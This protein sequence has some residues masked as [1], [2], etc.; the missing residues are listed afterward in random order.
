MGERIELSRLE[1]DV[2]WEHL[3]LGSLPTVLDMPRHGATV[4]ERNVL[5]KQAWK[6]LADKKLGWPGQVE[7]TVE[8]R[9]RRLVRP[10]WE[11]DARLWLTEAG[12]RTSALIA[13][14]RSV[15]TV[16]VLDAERLT[17]AA[18]PTHRITRE[19]VAL[20]PPHPPGTGGSI[21]VPADVLDAAAARAG[22]NPSALRRVLHARGVGKGE[23]RKITEASTGIIRLGH[24]GAAHTPATGKRIRAGH[25]VSVYDSQHG[26]YLFT[27]KPSGDQW[28]ITLLPGT[29]AAIL[30]QL[31]ELLDTLRR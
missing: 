24:F 15:A 12:P 4:E 19:A 21:T 13:A 7:S 30:R 2:L 31:D 22:S 11:L 25:A 28:W 26:R 14:A 1:F 23:A 16:A 18:A 3:E 5:S 17:L 6:S 10:E 27:R 9:L 20:L 29:D 8:R